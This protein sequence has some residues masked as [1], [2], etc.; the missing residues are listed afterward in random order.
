MLEYLGEKQ[1]KYKKRRPDTGI[2]EFD[3]HSL[4]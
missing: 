2:P 4:T 3:A 1:N